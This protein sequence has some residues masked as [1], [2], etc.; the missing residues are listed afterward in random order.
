MDFASDLPLLLSDFG[1]DALIDGVPVHGKLNDRYVPAFDSLMP[2]EGA[3]FL[4]NRSA[5]LGA[6]LV[7]GDKTF[8]VAAIED[9][10]NGL[11]R[12]RLK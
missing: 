6:T 10:G 11:Y 4:A 12:W 3:Y 7:A 9:Q 8:T 2:G 1:V 5:A